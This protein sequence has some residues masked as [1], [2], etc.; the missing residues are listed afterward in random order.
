MKRLLNRRTFIAFIGAYVVAYFSIDFVPLVLND[1][2]ISRGLSI[3]EAGFVVTFLTLAMAITSAVSVKF[4]A[5]SRRAPIARIGL[6]VAGVAFAAAAFAPS[7]VLIA[8]CFAL[9]GT[10]VGASI[11][12]ASAALAATADPDAATTT[13]TFINRAGAGLIITLLPFL[14]S[15]LA[16]TLGALS[17]LMLIS[18]A[19][20][21]GLPESPVHDL[22]T[23]QIS[24]LDHERPWIAAAL[25]I[26]VGAFIWCLSEDMV[27][28]IAATVAI[29]AAGVPEP[30]VGLV[31]S[32]SMVGGI[33][34][35]LFSQPLQR[36]LKRRNAL[37][38]TI[39]IG[40]A[41]KILTL[42]ATSPAMFAT[43]MF[44]W[45][46]AYAMTLIYIIGF[47]ASIDATGRTSTL[48]SSLYLAG[49]P[50]SPLVG[51][52]LAE[53]V[54]AFEFS[55]CA[56]IPSTL[57]ALLYLSTGNRIMNSAHSPTD[58]PSIEHAEENVRP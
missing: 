8:A 41:S 36:L 33:V 45:G 29:D 18:S 14:G 13:V 28:A 2:T 26:G 50:L 6:L 47:A 46:T 27:Y 34:G 22:N 4:V 49:F 56:A 48:V 17:V 32:A 42:T 58:H 39:L 5:R 12:A 9:A 31:L 38:L 25:L 19:L 37:V 20:V 3:S 23:I 24:T 7:A 21:S 57:V 52:W 16:I 55:L 54:T 44:I 1:L 11:A 10:G 15:D 35:T 51:G 40:S 43:A 53:H 30:Q